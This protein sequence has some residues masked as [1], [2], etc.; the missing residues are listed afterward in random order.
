MSL[1]S[2]IFQVIDLR[3]FSSVW[4]WITLAAVWSTVS[5]WIL[6]VPFDLVNRARKHGGAAIEELETLVRINISRTLYIADVAGSWVVALSFFGL[7]VLGVLAIGYGVTLA[8]AVML[9]V[10]PVAAVRALGVRLARRIRRDNLSGA[11]LIRAMARHRTMVQVI[12]I[13]SIMVTVFYGMW[14]TMW[15]HF[16]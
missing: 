14:K 16:Y 9:I 3:S 11:Q 8:Q 7:G 6:G 10:V 4:Y 5:H 2:Q 1:Y 13:T 15:F 12:G